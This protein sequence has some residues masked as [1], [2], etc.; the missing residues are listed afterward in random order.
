MKNVQSNDAKKKVRKNIMKHMLYVIVSDFKIVCL[1]DFSL[2]S[3]I[4][5][6]KQFSHSQNWIFIAYLDHFSFAFLSVSYAESY[7]EV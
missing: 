2:L 3:N 7:L 1:G 4:L 5:Y 6:N